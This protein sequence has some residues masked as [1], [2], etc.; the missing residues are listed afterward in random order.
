MY[1]VTLSTGH[2][3]LALCS[4]IEDNGDRLRCHFP[5]AE[6]YRIDGDDADTVRQHLAQLQRDIVD[7]VRAQ[8]LELSRQLG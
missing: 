1:Y 3:N 5:G 6:P 8:L 2:L 7:P 4:V